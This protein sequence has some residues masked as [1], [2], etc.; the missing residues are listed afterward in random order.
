MPF[1]AESSKF[2]VGMGVDFETGK[3]KS[4][5]CVIGSFGCIQ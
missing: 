5:I 3:I 1:V 2:K 4:E